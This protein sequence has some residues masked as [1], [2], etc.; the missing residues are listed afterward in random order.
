MYLV[1]QFRNYKPASTVH[2][3]Q[4]MQ[5]NTDMTCDFVIEIVFKIRVTYYKQLK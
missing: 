1:R 4:I 5:N 3:K 2:Q